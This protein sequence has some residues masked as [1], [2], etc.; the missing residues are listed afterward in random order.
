MAS[1]EKVQR[2]LHGGQAGLFAQL[3]YDVVSY[4]HLLQFTKPMEQGTLTRIK[5]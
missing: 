5:V 1:A 3:A 2:D 4:R